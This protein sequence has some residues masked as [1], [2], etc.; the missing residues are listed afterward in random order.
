MQATNTIEPR[1]D[2]RDAIGLYL[3]LIVLLLV[4]VGAGY[5]GFWEFAATV[6]PQ[7]PSYNL[8]ALA[9]IAG[10]ASFFSPC[11]FPLL[12]SYLAFYGRASTRNGQVQQRSS[13]VGL[14]L[15]AAAGVVTFTLILGGAIGLLGAGFASAFS[16]TD[17]NP[18][19]SVLWFRGIVGG[20]LIVLG[21][22]Q[23]L[24]V[25]LKPGWVNALVWRAR[26][27]RE[28]TRGGVR[29]L[30]LYGFGYTAAGIGC[31]GPILAGLTVFSLSSGG[32]GSA[33]TVFSIFAATMGV[34]MLLV[35]GLVAASQD[36]LVQR[37]KASGDR[38]RQVAGVLLV[39]VGLF[40]LVTVINQP[41]FVQRFFPVIPAEGQAS[42]GTG[43]VSM[44][45]APPVLGLYEGEEIVFIHTEVSDPDVAAL[46]TEMMGPQVIVMPKLADTPTALLANVYI[47]VNGIEG[48]G[49][50]GF[51]PDVFDAVPDDE[52]YS[53][54][55]AVNLVAWRDGSR[56][57]RLGSVA[58]IETALAGR[59]VTLEQPGIVVNMPIL[60]WPDGER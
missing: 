60:T 46:L 26:P 6:M 40:T 34:L 14:G 32:F 49:P 29:T 15:S 4:V 51:Q 22:A 47:F 44:D 33:V 35:S 24:N 54:L 37:L 27:Q 16:M 5:F 48:S 3:L 50:F 57:R 55:R 30:Y 56:P 12:P 45:F 8:W 52:N 59:E 17:P 10:V 25:N 43:L 36:T 21:I 18:H 39:L 42:M 2:H 38:I 41:W 13:A 31:T 7:M 19:P 11:A 58:E 23:W 28:S 53:P 9:L 1:S 20:L